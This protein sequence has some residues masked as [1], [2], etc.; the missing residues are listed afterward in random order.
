M[1]MTSEQIVSSWKSEDYRLSLSVDEQSLLPENPAG[2]IE[3]SD[4]EL[5]G[6][7]GGTD[8]IGVCSAILLTLALS[9]ITLITLVSIKLCPQG[10]SS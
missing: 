9:G 6:I 8:T 7:D 3:L 1:I 10:T 4:Q 2:L 5:A